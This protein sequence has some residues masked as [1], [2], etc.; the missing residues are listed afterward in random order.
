LS[1]CVEFSFR[2]ALFLTPSAQLP[3]VVVF[4]RVRACLCRCWLGLYLTQTYPSSSF[5]ASNKS[6]STRRK[7]VCLRSSL[8][9]QLFA[10]IIKPSA[11]QRSLPPVAPP[12][13]ATLPS[14]PSSPPTLYGAG[15][16]SSRPS[17]SHPASAS[18]AAVSGISP[19]SSYKSASLPPPTESQAIAALFREAAGDSFQELLDLG[20]ST[21]ERENARQPWNSKRISHAS[22]SAPSDKRTS[23]LSV[24]STGTVITIPSVGGP[25]SLKNVS[26][27]AAIDVEEVARVLAFGQRWQRSNK[28]SKASSFLESSD[29]DSPVSP[30]TISVASEVVPD[31][32]PSSS[33]ALDRDDVSVI[34]STTTTARRSKT[35]K[36]P[37]APSIPQRADSLPRLLE[38]RGAASGP[39]P[40]RPPRSPL[41]G[42]SSSFSYSP[43]ATVAAAGSSFST[44]HNGP[45]R[46]LS[47]I[48][49]PLTTDSSSL[50]L[51]LHRSFIGTPTPPISPVE[52]TS[53]GV[54]S[55]S[56]PVQDSHSPDLWNMDAHGLVGIK[57]E[58]DEDTRSSGRGSGSSSGVV[59][60]RKNSVD[61]FYTSTTTFS[62]DSFCS[63]SSVLPSSS[64]P[65][66]GPDV[67][68]APGCVTVSSAEP[69]PTTSSVEG[70]DSPVDTLFAFNRTHSRPAR[71]SFLSAKTGS[72]A[73]EDP[74]K[75]PTDLEMAFDEDRSMYRD[76]QGSQSS[77]SEATPSMSLVGEMMEEDDVEDVGKRD[78]YKSR[79]R[80]V[81]E[82]DFAFALK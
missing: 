12:P 14:P 71:R 73:H 77:E 17:L 64:S 78:E 9:Y 11:L 42:S 5:S 1:F 59:Q 63:V 80:D 27:A 13:S 72:Y 33:P 6:P 53:L 66:S 40:R 81:M 30:V 45:A 82:K 16:S 48:P 62:E 58:C 20:H 67:S 38:S 52:E 21:Q 56:A 68:D 54:G 7:Q 26:R 25:P 18:L 31:R 61:S 2:A 15:P 76:H 79:S 29:E 50:A 4:Q 46:S 24:T 23:L 65:P 36:F 28:L 70:L 55:S 51:E 57:E 47:S 37:P 49:T 22:S 74:S 39:V 32:D 43:S 8:C 34:T 19:I 60:D 10:L 44:R 69:S 3:P 75:T 41:R 35:K